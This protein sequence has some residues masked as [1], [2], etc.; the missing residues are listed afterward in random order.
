MIGETEIQDGCEIHFSTSYLVDYFFENQQNLKLVITPSSITNKQYEEVIDLQNLMRS[1]TKTMEK[2]LLYGNTN[3][4]FKLVVIAEPS[5][6]QIRDPLQI[7]KFFDIIIIGMPNSERRK[8]FIEFYNCKDKLFWRPMYQ[9]ETVINAIS[10]KFN[11]FILTKDS[12]CSNDFSKEIKFSIFDHEWGLIGE[13]KT[14][15]NKLMNYAITPIL[16]SEN[17]QTGQIQV[18]FNEFQDISSRDLLNSLKFYSVIAIDFTESNGLQ[19]NEKS[20]HFCGTKKDELT[21]LNSNPYKS[22]LLNLESLLLYFN[23]STIIPFFSFGGVKPGNSS[24]DFCCDLYS[25]FPSKDN[26]V[27]VQGLLT[28]YNEVINVFKLSA[29]TFLSPL[30]EYILNT[31]FLTLNNNPYNYYI[32]WILID[33]DI[34]DFDKA[35]NILLNAFNHGLSV[36]ICG[37]GDAKF[38]LMNDFGI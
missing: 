27:G 34:D 22:A 8:I 31:F 14:S 26:L 16:D 19:T 6:T 24:V 2:E 33:G 18:K 15:I 21:L 7:F 13:A 1:K 11:E 23:S 30:F 37:I 5:R 29:P 35:E 17:N 25:L 28:V 12:I 9:S 10:P 36:I 4:K 32:V 20:L 3:D 38:N